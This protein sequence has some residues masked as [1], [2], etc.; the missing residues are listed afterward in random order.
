MEIE[1]TVIS[2]ALD[3]K[4]DQDIIEYVIFTSNTN[5]LRNNL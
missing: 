5:S 4:Y 3:S 2:L 1:L